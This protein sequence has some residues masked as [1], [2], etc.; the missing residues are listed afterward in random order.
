MD[1]ENSEGIIAGIVFKTNGKTERK[2]WKYETMDEKS[3]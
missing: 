1:T 2:R 3:V